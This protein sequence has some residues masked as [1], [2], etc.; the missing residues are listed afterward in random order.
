MTNKKAES[1][2]K[3][4]SEAATEQQPEKPVC[5]VIMPISAIHNYAQEHWSDVKNILFDV[6]ESAGFDPN[7]VSDADDVGIIQKRIVQNIYNNDIV[8][9]D[10]SAKNPNVMFE[11][12]MRLAFDKATIVIKDDDTDFSFD[13]S[14]IEH[15]GYPRDLRFN[16]INSFRDTLKIKLTATYK[17]SKEDSNYSTFLK[18]FGE[19]TV[20]HLQSKEVS[21][22]AFILESINEV[23]NEMTAFRKQFSSASNSIIQSQ[24]YNSQHSSRIASRRTIEE[25]ELSILDYAMANKIYDATDLLHMRE[26]IFASTSLK[27]SL[28]NL[29][30]AELKELFLEV[31]EHPPFLKALSQL[32]DRKVLSPQGA[33]SA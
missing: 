33:R 28:G 6:I 21:P 12:G 16:K 2:E 29:N 4:A 7:L 22:D 11:L 3:Q 10:V 25:L 26:D 32:G 14:P 17:R 8:V 20:A 31:F 19:F 24:K 13:T 18:N 27:G 9:C 15:I 23:K 1:E 5:G 30:I